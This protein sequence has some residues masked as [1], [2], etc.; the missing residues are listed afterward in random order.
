M[1]VSQ[2]TIQLL[3]NASDFEYHISRSYPESRQNNNALIVAYF[4]NFLG[5]G[6]TDDQQAIIIK[7]MPIETL[8]RARRKRVEGKLI[9]KGYLPF[10]DE[11]AK[12]EEKKVLSDEFKEY[13]KPVNVMA[14]HVDGRI[15]KGEF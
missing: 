11:I 12:D 8:T 10:K 3:D 6:L 9:K 2:E 14:T 5:I 1:K 15:W 7:A 13:F 4:V